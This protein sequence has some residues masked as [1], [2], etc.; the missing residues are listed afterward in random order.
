MR[1]DGAASKIDRYRVHPG[2]PGRN[3]VTEFKEGYPVM[4]KLPAPLVSSPCSLDSH[5]AEISHWR[6]ALLN[7]LWQEISKNPGLKK[8]KI[9]NQFLR[10]FNSGA[11]LPYVFKNL[12]KISRPT[13]YR[14]IKGYKKGGIEALTPKKRGPRATGI[15]S[16][17]KDFLDKQL[18]DPN[19]RKISDVIADC[20]TYFGEKSTSNPA[21]L[22]R[23]I[24]DFKKY[25]FDVWVKAREGQ[26]AWNNK[27][28]PY[29]DRNPMLLEFG[30]ALVADGR[31]CDLNVLDPITGKLKRPTI[32]VFLDWRSTLPAGLE[33]SFSEDTQ[34]ITTA[35]FNA[36]MKIG[37]LPSVIYTDNGRAFLSKIFTRKTITIG[38]TK[39]S[40]M[41]EQLNQLGPEGHKIEYRQALK[42]HP[43]S[44]VTERWWRILGDRLERRFPSYVGSSIKNKPAYLLP[45]E[46]RAKALHDDWVPKVPEFNQIIYQWIEEYIDEPRP[47]RQGLTPRQMFE[48]GKGTGFDPRKLFYLMMVSEVKTVSRCRFRFAGV[49]WEGPCLYGFEGKVIIRYSLSDFSKIYVFDPSDNH[50]MGVVTQTTAAHPI[51]DSQ[52]AKKIVNLR[53]VYNRLTT[54]RED[55][56]RKN[57]FLID[58]RQPS[59]LLEY[60]ETEEVKK[61]RVLPFP[62]LD[63][64]SS[65]E[66]VPEDADPDKIDTMADHGSP[67]SGPFYP[68]LEEWYREYAIR[69]DPKCLIDADRKAMKEVEDSVWYE[70]NMEDESFRR[71]FD[72]IKFNQISMPE[73]LT[74]GG[75]KNERPICADQI[76]E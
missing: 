36:L 40:G 25:R 14:W 5:Q 12:K 62:L 28:A 30:E 23:Y 3:I 72:R 37:K 59:D 56:I 70:K 33:V 29:Q 34:S 16:N 32:V 1:E 18:I 43:Q 22:R 75:E 55:L 60:I 71:L 20:K 67:L 39:I 44:K 26:T 53:R 47:K 11:L 65:V 8:R 24:D 41:I 21:K 66:S 63:G 27:V 51:K 38:G 46:P 7:A 19:E 49:D 45:N 15:L 73:E 76:R 61:E 57:D 17:E 69:Q 31:R 74:P 42:Y 2:E 48:E 50:Y 58:G 9:I 52:A 6:F 54:K 10:G 13:L 35:L 4:E 68:T 64:P